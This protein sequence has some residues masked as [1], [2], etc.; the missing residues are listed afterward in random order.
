[1][2][3]KY[4]LILIIGISI[5]FAYF[6]YLFNKEDKIYLI[7]F[8]DG[9]AS[10]ETS[11]NIDGISYNDYIKEYFYSKKLLKEYNSSFSKKNY[12]LNNLINDIEN[13]I[14]D[15][16][17]DKYIKQ[18]IHKANIIT[19][20][21][22]EDE[23]TKLAITNDLTEEKLK[24][25]INNYDKLL[26]IIKELTESKV[27]V[28]GLYENDYLNKTNTIILNSEIANIVNQY[29]YT[30]VNISDLLKDKE[31]YLNKNSYY[32]SYKAHEIIAEIIIHSL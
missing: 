18:I 28:I 29:E 22:G 17:I 14:K 23:I 26:G 20:N 11:Y 27:V 6:I 7:S 5:I 3:R 12:T 25:F 19:I 2:R 10:G 24:E 30:F 1:L 21:F 8:G 15:E 13:N 16:K 4:K 31:Y 9:V 32:F